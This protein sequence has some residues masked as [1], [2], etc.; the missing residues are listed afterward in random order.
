MLRYE[1]DFVPRTPDPARTDSPHW[2][3]NC[4]TTRA[5]TSSSCSPSRSGAGLTRLRVSRSTS[6]GRSTESDPASR[7]V[8]K[9][10][11]DGSRGDL[12]CER[13]VFARPAG[14]ALDRR[15][16]LYVADP[17]AK[18]VVVILPDDGSVAGVL[19]GKLREPVD[20]AVSPSGLIYVADR[21]AGL[22]VRFNARFARCGDFVPRNVT[23]LPGQ[24]APIAVAID[25]DGAIVVVDAAHPRL[26]RFDAGGRPLPD[27]E[28]SA[29]VRSLDGGTVA[30]DALQKAYGRTAPRFLVD[31]CRPPHPSNDGGVR[32]AEV[33]RAIRLST[34]TEPVEGHRRTIAERRRIA[35]CTSARCTPPSFEG[36]GG[37]HASTRNRGAVRP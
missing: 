29:A 12:V 3:A 24:P 15:G 28:L 16:L 31:A 18:R 27:L 1:R 5:A 9:R 25:A 6:T 11:C 4:S 17:L 21:A 26:L 34:P 35:R 30:L 8:R 10:C 19:V 22:I 13:G 14:L 37:R 2:A 36:C 20:V 7:S 33:H 32:L 23:G